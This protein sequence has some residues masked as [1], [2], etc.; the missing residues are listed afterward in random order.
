MSC[1]TIGTGGNAGPGLEAT[2]EFAEDQATLIVVACRDFAIEKHIVEQLNAIG[3]NATLR[4]F[5]MLE[6]AKII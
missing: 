4:T 3:S 2:R 1:S 6:S 5:Q